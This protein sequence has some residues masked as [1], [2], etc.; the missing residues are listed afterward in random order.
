[1]DELTRDDPAAPERTFDLYGERD[2]DGGHRFVWPRFLGTPEF[3]L[4]CFC[5]QITLPIG[6]LEYALRA[7]ATVSAVLPRMARDSC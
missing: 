1:M 3:A 7:S 6:R 5:S 2:V 4:G